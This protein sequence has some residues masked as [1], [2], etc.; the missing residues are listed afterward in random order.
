MSAPDAPVLFSA[1]QPASLPA[2]DRIG[3]TDFAEHLLS[4][5]EKHV[6]AESLVIGVEGAW[7]SGKSTVTRHLRERL[8]SE[9]PLA[10]RFRNVSS[11]YIIVDFQPWLIGSREGLLAAFFSE[12]LLS[13]EKAANHD[14]FLGLGGDEQL[15]RLL[16]LLRTYVGAIAQLGPP[17]E[18]A[19]KLSGHPILG[20]LAKMLFGSLGALLRT[21]VSDTKVEI[22]ASLRRQSRRVLI[23]IDDLDRLDPTELS[24]VVR[25]VRSVA[26]FANITYILSYDPEVVSEALTT[27]LK[28]DGQS[29]LQK[30]VQIRFSVPSPEDFDLRIWLRDD[31]A[32]LSRQAIHPWWIET[33][34]RLASTIMGL[35]GQQLRTPRDV[36]RAINAFT[37]IRVLAPFPLDAADALWLAVLE[38]TRPRLIDWFRAY[39]RARNQLDLGASLQDEERSALLQHLTQALKA[40]SLSATM[41]KDL[42]SEVLPWVGGFSFLSEDANDLSKWGLFETSKGQVMREAENDRRISHPRFTRSYFA[43]TSAKGALQLDFEATLASAMESSAAFEDWIRE[44]KTVARPQGGPMSDYIVQQ[45]AERAEGL[46]LD[47]LAVVATG[48]SNIMDEA[49]ADQPLG[50]WGRHWI[51]VSS[52]QVFTTYLKAAQRGGKSITPQVEKI[53]SDGRALGWLAWWHRDEV[54]S[55]EKDVSKAALTREDIGVAGSALVR[56]Y[57]DSGLDLAKRPQ[58]LRL[59]Y[60][61]KAAGD[62]EGA[63]QWVRENVASDVGLLE[64]VEGMRGWA[65]VNGIAYRPGPQERRRR[66]P[67]L[68]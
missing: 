32:R 23:F 54:Q 4:V 21:S 37:A 62:L 31:V 67:Q 30:I 47:Q 18:A 51:W 38:T 35:T 44:E 50:E 13:F 41:G 11:H 1:D 58:F 52:S 19:A 55:V 3:V 12:L 27:A 14:S 53:F 66:L 65:A 57:K 2:S 24:E 40:D 39:M 15:P 20:A 34:S 9:R 22:D 28:L 45:I 61:W 29:Y 64:V 5:L 16:S 63:R 56:R 42:L 17:A 8:L 68:R 49:V 59:L 43:F 6:G 36:I 25:L 48:L 60:D 46:S 10:T 33:E 26:D 7:G